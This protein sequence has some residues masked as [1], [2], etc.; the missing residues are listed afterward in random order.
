LIAT[1]TARARLP[2][3]VILVAIAA[4]WLVALFAE[5]TGGR[6]VLHHDSLIHGGLPL[7]AG[8]V[9]FLLGWQVMIAAMMLPSSL[10][11][12]RLF[13]RISSAQPRPGL[14]KAAFLY[15]YIW[16]WTAFGAVAFIGDVGIHRA[17]DAWPWLSGHSWLIPG[18]VLLLAGAFQFSPLKDACLKKC[19]NPGVFLLSRY[20][21][22]PGEA[23]RLGRDHGLFCLGCCWALML[24]SF[25][26]GV[27]NLVWM[28]VLTLIMVI[29]KT[30]PRGDRG[31]VPFGIGLLLMGVLVLAGPGWLLS[32]FAAR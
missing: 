22:G 10:P 12:I 24:V 16:V 18:S 32:L 31:V 13:N 25:A 20:R 27:A 9:V 6:T 2:N 21:R 7:W 3:P 28:A 29:E 8:L 14:A 4:A 23:F 17:V 15:G 11:L 19:R 26:A 1:L 5:A 30:G